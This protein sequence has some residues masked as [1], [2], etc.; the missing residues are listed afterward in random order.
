MFFGFGNIGGSGMVYF[1]DVT[2][3]KPAK[4]CTATGMFMLSSFRSILLYGL[5]AS[6]LGNVDYMFAG[7][8]NLERINVASDTDWTYYPLSGTYMFYGC[9]NLVGQQNTQCNGYKTNIDFAR[10]DGLNGPGYFTCAAAL[11]E[12]YM[13]TNPADIESIFAKSSK[14]ESRFTKDQLKMVKIIEFVNDKPPAISSTAK[15]VDPIVS[16]SAYLLFPVLALV[17]TFCRFS[18]SLNI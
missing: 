10:V 5:D 8:S 13:T 3:A 17:V 9:Y 2:P 7:C 15:D 1:P 14:G 6:N 16:K 4:G 11:D 12:P 18:K